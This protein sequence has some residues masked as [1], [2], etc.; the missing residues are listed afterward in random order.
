MA[1]LPYSRYKHPFRQE[2]TVDQFE[3]RHVM[4]MTVDEQFLLDQY[5]GKERMKR[6]KGLTELENI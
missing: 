1:K 6:P 3:R 4:G 5:G 2:F